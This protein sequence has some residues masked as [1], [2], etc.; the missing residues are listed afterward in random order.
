MKTFAF[1]ASFFGAALAGR[2]SY[3]HLQ[4]NSTA[5][6]DYCYYDYNGTY[7]VDYG[8]DWGSEN[9]PDSYD[10]VYST[11]YTCDEY[12][13]EICET[14]YDDG[15]DAEAAAAAAAVVATAGAAYLAFWVFY[16]CGVICTWIGI[17]LCCL[18]CCGVMGKKCC[19]YDCYGCKKNKS[20]GPQVVV[21]QQQP[22]MHQQPGQVQMMQQPQMQPGMGMQQVQY[23]QAPPQ[24]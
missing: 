10:S 19:W 7:D 3:R 4:T 16:A 14:Y 24:Q 5:S 20:A 12:S 2:D 9:C 23:V 15:S 11:Y 1:A 6:D 17:L 18:C 8:Y 21:V 22:G 13:L